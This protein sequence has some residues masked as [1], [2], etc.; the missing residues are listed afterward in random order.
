MAKRAFDLLLSALGLLVLALHDRPLAHLGWGALAFFVLWH[1]AGAAVS[2]TARTSSLTLMACQ[3]SRS[4]RCMTVLNELCCSGRLRR[5]TA[6]WPRSSYSRVSSSTVGL[7]MPMT[8]RR[9]H[10]RHD[11]ADPPDSSLG[12]HG[13]PP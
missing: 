3:V 6:T 5:T 10:G 4:S 9:C 2:T 12:R 7:L 8:A 1:G 11:G 13:H